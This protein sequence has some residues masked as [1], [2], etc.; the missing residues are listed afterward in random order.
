[1]SWTRSEQSGNTS[2]TEPRA[3]PTSSETIAIV[4]EWSFVVDASVVVEFVAPGAFAAAA[5]RFIGGLGW[6]TPLGLVSPDLLLLESANALRKLAL[7]KSISGAAADRAV[8]R[9]AELGIATVPSPL[10]L[11]VAWSLR[12]KLTIYDAVYVALAKKLEIALVTADA[13]LAR[14]TKGSRVKMWVLDDPR[15]SEQLDAMER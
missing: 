15:F 2:G 4:D 12:G 9:L 10:L 8:G 13:R 11:D 14:A 1:M 6:R 7:M 5:D 3:P